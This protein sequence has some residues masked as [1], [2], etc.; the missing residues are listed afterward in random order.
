[1][2]FIKNLFG[3]S[4]EKR[5]ERTPIEVIEEELNVLLPNKFKQFLKDKISPNKSA[6]LELLDGQ[7]KFLDSLFVKNV[8]DNYESVIRVSND[9][10][11]LQYPEEEELVKIPF[12]KSTEGDGFKYLYFIAERQREANETVFLRDLDSPATGRIAICNQLPFV[13][14]K[15]GEIDNQIIV[16]NRSLNFSEANNWIEI[17][18]FIC[19]WKD[20][21]GVNI[22]EETNDDN[23]K[24]DLYLS[25]YIMENN[26]ENFSKIEVQV[27]MTY[28]NKRILSA[29]AFEIDKAALLTQFANNVNYRIFYHKLVCIIGTFATLASDLRR[30]H[31]IEIVEYLNTLDLRELT[32]QD[33]SGIEVNRM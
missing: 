9:F 10:N 21:Y 7:Y 6:K 31:N 4:K 20:S 1:M 19:I 22:R 24:I 27:D 8:S 33:F 12:A 11:S 30:N 16:S 18:N 17:P 5:D 14:R 26:E 13:L 29:M 32:K 2:S 23:C 15:V 3:N 25:N 28:Q